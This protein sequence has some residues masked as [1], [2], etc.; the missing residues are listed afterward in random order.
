[1]ATLNEG[2]AA[3]LFQT[4]ILERVHAVRDIKFKDDINAYNAIHANDDMDG[5]EDY[6]LRLLYGDEKPD[7]GQDETEKTDNFS[8]KQRPG[9]CHATPLG[10]F[11][12]A[13]TLGRRVGGP[14][15]RGQALPAETPNN[16]ADHVLHDYEED[17]DGDANMAR[18]SKVAALQA[19]H[20]EAHEGG[21]DGEAMYGDDDDNAHEMDEKAIDDNAHEMDDVD[22]A[23]SMD[24]DDEIPLPEDNGELDDDYYENDKSILR[25][26]ST[27]E[28]EA[29]Q[30]DDLIGDADR[31][32]ASMEQSMGTPNVDT[33]TRKRFLSNGP[34]GETPRRTKGRMIDPEPEKGTGENMTDEEEFRNYYKRR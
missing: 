5:L 33:P 9:E 34:D 17:E 21:D 28:A 2:D 13:G 24:Q 18:E 15:A 11:E 12:A 8:V 16:G 20:L 29:D 26:E 30:D 7:K 32:E 1:M 23:N 25:T 4:S 27:A 31:L 19:G 22:G 3:S 6:G 14:P 10:R